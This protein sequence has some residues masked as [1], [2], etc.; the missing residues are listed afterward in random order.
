MSTDFHLSVYQTLCYPSFVILGLYPLFCRQFN[1]GDVI[2]QE[3]QI[4]LMC[5]IES[6]LCQTFCSLKL[7]VSFRL[8]VCLFVY[9]SVMFYT[10]NHDVLHSSIHL[11]N[12][13]MNLVINRAS[14]F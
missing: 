4:F 2:Y 5:K 11:M 10:Y 12:M 14:G 13:Q 8:C 9:I 1:K 7:D 6:R 3:N